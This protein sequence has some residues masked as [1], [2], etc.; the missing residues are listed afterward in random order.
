M[1]WDNPFGREPDRVF[2]WGALALIML[3]ALFI[4]V[5][6]FHGPSRHEFDAAQA[7][8]MTRTSAFNFDPEIKE[9]AEQGVSVIYPTHCSEAT[10]IHYEKLGFCVSIP[11]EDTIVYNY[12]C[13][14][15]WGKECS[16]KSKL[17]P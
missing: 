9:A 17:K 7:E 15:S 3:A 1:E 11:V 5:V 8:H 12:F 2:A 4:S 13:K 16:L 10:K 14:I 6:I